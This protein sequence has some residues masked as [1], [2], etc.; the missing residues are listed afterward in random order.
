MDL[1]S[2]A[3]TVAWMNMPNAGREKA[4]KAMPALH[5]RKHM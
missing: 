5:P 3:P 2:V 4:G 1:Y